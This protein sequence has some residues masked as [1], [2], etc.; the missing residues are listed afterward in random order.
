[1]SKPID[2]ADLLRHLDIRS[3]GVSARAGDAIRA[4]L[5]ENAKYAAYEVDAALTMAQLSR[6]VIDARTKHDALLAENARL[7]E[8]LE[9]LTE[10]SRFFVIATG[11]HSFSLD[12]QMFDA[13]EHAREVLNHE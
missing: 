7:R 3:D 11:W 8:A 9:K 4:L 12:R 5:A 10:A 13:H 1:M 2:Y 6:D